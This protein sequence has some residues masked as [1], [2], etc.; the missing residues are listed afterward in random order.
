MALTGLMDSAADEGFD[1]LARLAAHLLRAPFAFLT[2]VDD[3]RSYWKSRIGIEE[4]GPRENTLDES[5]CQYVVDSGEPLVLADVREDPRTRHNP[6]IRSMGVVA[7]AGFPVHTPDGHVLGTLCVV[8]TV[9]RQWTDDDVATLSALAEV[10]SRE[11]ALRAAATAATAALTVA[12]RER[13][14]AEVLARIVELLTDGLDLDAVWS[15]VV[16]LAVPGLADFGFIHAVEP[17]AGL[18]V[19]ACAHR[20]RAR[21]TELMHVVRATGG[22]LDDP[23]GPGHVLTT[24]RTEVLHDL[25]SDNG[26]TQ[27]QTSLRD[28]MEAVRTI[29]VPLSARG[30]TI[31]VLTLARTPE[32]PCYDDRD[33]ELVEA[34]A[35]RAALALD[36]ALA[37]DTAH[38]LSVHLQQA[39]LPPG[40]PQPD[41]LQIVSR[42]LP[43]S[44]SQAVGGDW[45]DAFPDRAG[46]TAV[47]IGD[48]AGHDIEAA[49]TMGQLRTMVRVAGHGGNRTPAEVLERVDDDTDAVGQAVFATALVVRVD[50]LDLDRAA[51][52]R[53]VTWSSAGHLLPLL[54]T[55]DGSARLLD[56]R[57]DLVLGI[58]R[59]ASGRHDHEAILAP[60]E[61]L[62]LYTDGLV[63]RRG[64]DLDVGL[65]RLVDTV[66]ELGGLPLDALCDQVLRRMPTDGDDDVAVIAVR[67]SPPERRAAD[68]VGRRTARIVHG[69]RPV[70]AE[71]FVGRDQPMGFQREHPEPW[72]SCAS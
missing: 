42:Y 37:Y 28:H 58:G 48:V 1:R 22:R 18:V 21:E 10:A 29:T 61:T 62:L 46:A 44:R 32:S 39:L 9:V 69:E 57:P 53:A 27:L 38:Q 30:E 66:A 56:G 13:A 36:N 55:A 16:G 26:L 72:G 54:V 34:I 43:A 5:F 71:Q 12:E 7:W 41:G 51:G 15:A 6:S 60:A 23:S 63:E 24:D 68:P 17:G 20:D 4:A 70:T 49:T 11:V 67:V 59:P 2:V 65:Q 64:E 14:R 47:V 19:H 3:R 45:Y 35:S 8:D 50:P 52:S 25:R 40:L 31:A 33:L